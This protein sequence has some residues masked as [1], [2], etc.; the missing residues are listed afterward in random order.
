MEDKKLYILKNVGKL[1]LKHGIRAVTMDDVAQDFGI[2]KKTLYQF[3][4]DKE[5]LVSQVIDYYLENPMFNLNQKDLGNSIDRIFALREHVA[6]ILKHFNNNLEFELKKQYPQLYKKVHMF[7]RE[8]IYNDM[9]RNIQSGIKEGLY[10]ED[11]DADFVAR[12]QVGRMLFTLNPDNEIFTEE[13]TLSIH[14]FDK[15]IDYHMHA[16]CTEKGLS[17]Y[18]QQL[19]R[20]QNEQE[21]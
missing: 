2:S 14:L 11:L 16:I 3:F 17:Y 21:N 6:Q 8:C 18:K 9:I 15:V 13:E 4:N 1:Y 10:R 12:L 5:D 19:N 20:F 7:K